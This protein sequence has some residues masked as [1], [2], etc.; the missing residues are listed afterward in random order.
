MKAQTK[1]VNLRVN[2]VVFL[3]PWILLICMVVVS[4]VNGDAFLAGL[5]MVTGWIL[6][7]FAWAFNLVTVGCVVTVIF[8]YFSPLGK[9]RIGGRKAHPMMS[10]GNLVWITLC[11][12][13]AAG[14][15]FWAC[16]EP[17]YQMYAP[18]AAEGVEAGSQGAALFAM[19]TMF[20]EWT[21]S[22][23]A[24][25]TV[26][27][28][29]F[30]FV[31]YN[32]KKSYSI[33]SAF[34]PL[35]GDRV[36]KYN[37][38]ID[39]ICL[40]TLVTG[41]AASLGTGTMTIAGGIEN[42]FGVKSGPATWG[43][44]IALIVITFVISSVSGIMKGIRILSNINAKVYMVL[45]AFLLIFGPTAF[46]LNFSVESLGVYVRDF[47]QMSFSTGAIFGDS[48]AKSWPIFYWCNWLSWTPITAIFLARILR[49]YTI[50]DAIHCNFVIPSLFATL[51]MG[52]FSTASIYYEMHGQGFYEILQSSGPEAV[53]YALFRQLPAAVIIIPFYLFIVFISFVT[54]SDSNTTAMA[55]LCTNGITQ[56][57]QNSPAWLKIVWGI[58]LAMVTWILISFAGIDGIKAASN[59]GGFPN[60]FLMILIIVAVVKIARNPKKYDTYKEDYDENGMPIESKRLPIEEQ[61]G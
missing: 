7:N 37:S 3:P 53:V 57:E 50:K 56:E 30:A 17:M 40:F 20:L 41:M 60:M 14:I 21:W 12:T 36:V 52:L 27:T 43:I 10:F 24:I 31:F 28:I 54:A 32:M 16:A 47:F 9:V 2:K 59:L 45:L 25:Y 61:E 44:I 35:F 4:L 51:W 13:I 8:V 19:K 22:P 34:A 58:T 5:N 6:D 23:Y 29:I 38:I 26:A 33:G 11:T 1:E 48:W 46:M 55:G 49:G 15:L 18:A 42:V 39:I